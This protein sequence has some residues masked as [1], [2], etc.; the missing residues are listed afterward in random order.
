MNTSDLIRPYH[1]ARRAIIYV[2]QSTQQQVISNQESLRLQY[3][4]KHRA[5]E[6]GWPESSIDV[7]DKDLGRSGATTDGRAGYQELVAQAA[8]G[9]IGILI[10]YDATRLARNC[11]HWY[12]LL[13]LCGRA[14]CL[15]ADRD[16][17]YDPSSVNG[18]LLLGL[19]GQ[20]SELELHTIRA[21]MTAGVLN[22]AKRGDLALSLPTGLAR[23][24]SGEVVKH[25]NREVQERLS[26]IFQTMLE[27]RAVPRVVRVL[28]ERDLLVPRQDRYGDIQWRQPTASMVIKVLTNPA[29]AGVFVYGRTRIIHENGTPTS[30]R[31]HIAADSW[32]ACVP[33]KYPAYVSP[34]NFEK[35]AAMLRD[36]RGE[37]ERRKSRGIPRD[38]KALLQGIVYC[39]ECGHKMTVQYKGHA[40]YTCHYLHAQAGEPICQHVLADRIDTHVTQWFFD[41]LSPAEIDLSAST[42]LA[43]DHRRSELLKAQR[44]QVER[45]RH[46]AHLAERQYRHSEPENRLVTAEL[47]TRWELALRERKKA[48]DTLAIDEQKASCWAMPADLLEILHNIGPRL[49]ELWRQRLLSWSQKK[50]LFRCLVEKVVLRRT[51]DQV[52]TRVVWRGGDTSSAS[53]PVTVGRFSQLSDAQEIETAITS[54]ARNGHTDQQIAA[55]LTTAGHRSPRSSRVLPSTVMAIRLRHGILLKGSQSHPRLISGCLT[56]RQLAKNLQVPPH[57]IYDRIHNG[58]IQIAKDPAARTFL[59]PDKPDTLRQFRQLLAGEISSLAY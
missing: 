44:Q 24:G 25:P 21:R 15:I 28:R 30:R 35:I 16:G 19:K 45:L 57:W 34:E 11:S 6:L 13:D 12:Q 20:I 14:D 49:P 54:M 26:L 37:Y 9:H 5:R 32:K 41:A 1:L 10:A 7:V 29:Y 27:K 3:A 8:L 50:A 39:G 47:E 22:K 18:R 38:G 40:R 59:F 48:E 42:L 46:E 43:A 58:N 56:V 52:H 53:V 51:G 31:K 36:N 23:N 17:V 55:Q 2:R 33:G 4:L